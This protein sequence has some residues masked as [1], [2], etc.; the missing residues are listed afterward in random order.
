MSN[1]QKFVIPGKQA[2]PK[3]YQDNPAGYEQKVVSDSA[4]GF[5]SIPLNANKAVV[6]VE[7]S[8]IRWRDD[9]DDPTSSVGT[10]SFV[11][12]TIVL[13]GRGRINNFRAIRL[14]TTDAK[15]SINYY[16]RK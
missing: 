6:V 3:E 2:R 15:L 14:S 5:A 11:N 13:E 1:L 16:N 9:G 12:T 8:N 10:K 7:E 4:V